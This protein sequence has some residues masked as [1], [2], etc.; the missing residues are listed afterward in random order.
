VLVYDFNH[1]EDYSNMELNP[2][3]E[4]T[5]T[6]LFR[7]KGVTKLYI[8]NPRK[9]GGQVTLKNIVLEQRN[10]HPLMK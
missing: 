7:S 4:L 5:P 3:Q 10:L 8:W 6:L 1:S 9:K 2:Q